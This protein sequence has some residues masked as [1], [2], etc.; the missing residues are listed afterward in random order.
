MSKKSGKSSL[1]ALESPHLT[2]LM[3]NNGQNLNKNLESQLE[4]IG[5]EEVVKNEK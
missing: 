1:Q 4:P 2:N 5:E 3:I